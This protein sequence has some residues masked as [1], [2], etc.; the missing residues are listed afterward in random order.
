MSSAVQERL[1]ELDGV[2]DSVRV[3]PSSAR[4]CSPWS[5]CSTG[6]RPCVVP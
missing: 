2:L 3:T 6:N 5:T 1:S 4:S